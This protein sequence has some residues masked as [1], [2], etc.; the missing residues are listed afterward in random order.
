MDFQSVDFERTCYRLFWANLIQ[1]I[2]ETR[3][4]MSNVQVYHGEKKLHSDE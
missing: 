3:R 2:Q 1:I 4:Q